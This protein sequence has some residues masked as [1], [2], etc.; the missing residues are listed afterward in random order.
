[1][2]LTVLANAMDELIWVGD[3]TSKLM[4]KSVY[5][6]YRTKE[7]TVQWQGKIW[8]SYIPPRISIFIWKLVHNSLPMEYN[9]NRRGKTVDGGCVL[10]DDISVLED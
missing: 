7:I 4:V 8:Q 6:F 3:S 2:E 5:E 1:M 9:A 10:C